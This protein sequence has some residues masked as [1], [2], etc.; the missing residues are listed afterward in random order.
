MLFALSAAASAQQPAK[1]PRIGYLTAV[2]ISAYSTRIEA[3]RQGL[4]EHGY[5]E[6]KNIVIEWRSSEGSRDRTPELAAELVRLKV[7]VIVSGGLGATRAAKAATSTIPIVMTRDSDPVGNGFVASLA[8]P[9][10]NI[11]G[12]SNLASDLVGKRLELLK[13]ILPKLSQ[14]AV[15]GTSVNE[16]DVR[17]L[18]QLRIRRARWE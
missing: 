6:G 17:E 7:D 5:I 15:F 4:V 18:R 9:G 13:E 1:I 14:V 10:G 2:S 8:R 11:S 12:L 16:D 3:F